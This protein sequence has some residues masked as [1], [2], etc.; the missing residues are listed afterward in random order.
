MARYFIKLCNWGGKRPSC[1]PKTGLDVHLKDA[2]ILEPLLG[3]EWDSA[4]DVI[5]GTQRVNGRLVLHPNSYKPIRLTFD[6]KTNIFEVHCKVIFVNARGR[7]QYGVPTEN[8]KVNST[9]TGWK[10][11]AKKR[12]EKIASEEVCISY[13][14]NQEQEWL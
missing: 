6:P 9:K 11:V 7:P 8:E 10:A 14:Q 5:E 4:V 1:G 3:A 2:T 13:S 12:L